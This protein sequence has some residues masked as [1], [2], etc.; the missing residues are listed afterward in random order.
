MKKEKDKIKMSYVISISAIGI[1]LVSLVIIYFKLNHFVDYINS[2]SISDKI[3]EAKLESINMRFT[4]LY[5]W[6][7]F[8]ISL[9][10]GV[11]VLNWFNSKNV[12]KEQADKELSDIK[13]SFEKEFA[14]VEKVKFDIGIIKQDAETVLQ[15]MNEYKD[16]TLRSSKE[17]IKNKK[18]E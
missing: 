11:L 18:D 7:G 9:L 15:L 12:A 3:I 13:S 16:E 10:A 2:S 14:Y 4:D 17:T 6:I 5:I 8:F 1:S